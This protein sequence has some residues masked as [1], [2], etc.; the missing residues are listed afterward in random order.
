MSDD[1]IKFENE[2]PSDTPVVGL[3]L[4]AAK[5]K[6]DLV[7]DFIKKHFPFLFDVRSLFYFILFLV[8]VSLGW[9]AWSLWNN[10]FTQLYGWDYE[11]QYVCFYYTYW[12]TWHEFFRTGHFNLYSYNTFLGT[13]NIGSNSYY[14]LFDPFVTVMILF[15]RVWIPQMTAITTFAK[16]IVTA[17]LMRGY[18]KYMG[19]SEWTARIGAVA[20]A[21]SGFVN[22]M[23]G[24]PNF[25]SAAIYAPMI[26]WGIEKVIRERKPTLLVSVRPFSFMI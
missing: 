18:L 7:K 15:P 25:V 17:L 4:A 3:S 21:F 14:G 1:P 26:L 12:D 19:I 2:Q 23:V 22:F 6:K 16:L 10:Y 24:F 11:H 8:I 13:D 20:C 9:C 5:D